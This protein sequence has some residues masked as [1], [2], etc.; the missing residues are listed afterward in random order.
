MSF[1]N[2]GEFTSGTKSLKTVLDMDPHYKR[3]LYLVVALACK[4]LGMQEEAITI[5][6]DI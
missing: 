3:S 4:K 6:I 5:V 1:I 2:S